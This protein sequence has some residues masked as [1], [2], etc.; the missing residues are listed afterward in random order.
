MC[1]FTKEPYNYHWR[2]KKSPILTK[3][4]PIITKNSPLITTEEPSKYYVSQKFHMFYKKA[5]QSVA[6]TR[7]ESNMHTKEPCN[8][9]LFSQKDL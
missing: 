7:N 5:L 8:R 1:C 4:S 2:Q 3:K 6:N 9:A